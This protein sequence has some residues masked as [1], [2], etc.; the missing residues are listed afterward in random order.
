MKKSRTKPATKAQKE[1]IDGEVT[2]VK[3]E[4]KT[5]SKA[6]AKIEEKSVGFNAENLISQAIASKADVGTMER[7][8]AMRKSLKEEHAKEEF[9]RA[10]AAFQSECP[11]IK[12]TKSV[13]TK[14]EKVAYSYAP[15]ES[16]V[17]QVKPLLLKHGFSYSIQTETSDN[18]VK[19]TCTAKHQS[20]HSEPSSM[21]VPLG[22]KTK[23]MS[24]SQV[25][26]AAITFAK[27]YAFCNVFGILTGDDDNEAALPKDKEV[28]DTTNY[29]DKL[30]TVLIH[31]GAKKMS[32][33]LAMI[34]DVTGYSLK[35]FPKTNSP[36]VKKI[37]EAFIG[38]SKLMD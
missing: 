29:L 33:G 7:L 22:N 18:K 8:L 10:M 16:I 34:N 32:E 23:I 35:E 20:G 31:K 25:T 2:E 1:V 36:E 12:K 37:Y 24:D 38:S 17:S 27:R 4:R 19:A 15:L 21:E 9:D 14:E 13:E 28:K 26:A 30:K 5:T 3:K 6:I 11:V